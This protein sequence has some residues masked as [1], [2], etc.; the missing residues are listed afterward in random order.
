MTEAARKEC[1]KPKLSEQEKSRNSPNLEFYNV[2]RD[3]FRLAFRT[4]NQAVFEQD[5]S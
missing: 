3:R 2:G 4:L 1:A 5:V